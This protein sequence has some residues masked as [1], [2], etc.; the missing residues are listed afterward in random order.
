MRVPSKP[1]GINAGLFVPTES[2]LQP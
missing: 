1:G 2:A